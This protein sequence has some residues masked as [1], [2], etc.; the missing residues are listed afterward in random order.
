MKDATAAH[1]ALVDVG[2]HCRIA[3]FTDDIFKTKVKINQL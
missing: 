3:V 2:G 1:Q